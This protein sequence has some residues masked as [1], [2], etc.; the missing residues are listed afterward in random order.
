MAAVTICSDFG[1]QEN[2]VY[3]TVVP[4]WEYIQRKQIHYYE[5]IFNP[6]FTAALLTIAK[7]WKHLR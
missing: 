4:F 1:P 5:E 7:T 2:K 3:D 6:M